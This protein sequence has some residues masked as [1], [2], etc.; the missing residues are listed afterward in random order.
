MRKLRAVLTAGLLLAGPCHAAH[1][2]LPP[3]P[4]EA[5]GH[6]RHSRA[7][8]ISAYLDTLVAAAPTR[9]RKDVLG[10]SV[11]KRPIEALVLG[12]PAPRAAKPRLTVLLVGS[13]HGG[14]EPAGGEALL[15]VARDLLDGDLRPLLDDLDIIL[16]PDANPDGRDLK[17]RSNANRVNINTDFVL[18]SQ[19]ES[20][21]LAQPN[22]SNTSCRALS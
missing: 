10:H 5:A 3:T 8:E 2:A 7:G 22:T 15:T 14:A 11:Q 20:R 6:T 12:A 21:A 18:L 17:R 13:Q 1:L 9:A 4:L 16:I 19:P